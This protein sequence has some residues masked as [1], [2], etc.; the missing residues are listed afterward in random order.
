MNYELAK[1]RKDVPIGFFKLQ[2]NEYWQ[3]YLL[4][5]YN[6][7]KSFVRL[8]KEEFLVK[9][10]EF[11]RMMGENGLTKDLK[12]KL[13]NIDNLNS[14]YYLENGVFEKYGDSDGGMTTNSP[15]FVLKD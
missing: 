2:F 1:Q 7:S 12:W 9:G 6:T 4:P 10:Y 14:G 13:E 5:D 8:T 15:L 3:Y 11:L